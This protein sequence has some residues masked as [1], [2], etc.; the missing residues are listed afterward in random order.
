MGRRSFKVGRVR[1]GPEPGP[2]GE[3]AHF[4]EA[5]SRGNFFPSSP[6]VGRSPHPPPC[7]HHCGRLCITWLKVWNGKG[8]E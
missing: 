8:A 3:V 6:Q 4:I 5:H 2:P 1:P 7:R